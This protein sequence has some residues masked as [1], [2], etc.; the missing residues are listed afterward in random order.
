MGQ[1]SSDLSPVLTTTTLFHLP[2][3]ASPDSPYL[4]APEGPK[5]WLPRR[6]PEKWAHTMAVWKAELRAFGAGHAPANFLKLRNKVVRDVTE[7]GKE[8]FM[9]VWA[10]RPPVLRKGE[11]Q[12]TAD[13]PDGAL[14]MVILFF[15]IKVDTLG[16]LF[17][18]D[19][20]TLKQILRHYPKAPEGY[21]LE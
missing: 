10:F 14:G 15:D 5:L 17:D 9:E 13:H 6:L 19:S 11:K 2:G 18:D 20:L 3:V 8:L 12:A 16:E 4:P 7:L 1:A 21:K